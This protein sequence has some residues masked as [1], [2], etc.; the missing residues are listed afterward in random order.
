MII[1]F[2][3]VEITDTILAVTDSFYVGWKQSTN[4]LL[5]I[6]LD[7]NTDSKNMRFFNVS[8][9][10]QKSAIDGSMMI[11]PIVSSKNVLGTSVTQALNKNLQPKFFPNPTN[12]ILNFS[13]LPYKSKIAVYNLMGQL[14]MDVINS[15][16]VDLGNL[17]AG[18]YFI[19]VMNSYNELLLIDKC[20]KL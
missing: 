8:G 19:K 12:S 1:Q 20:I 14:E 3:L 2:Q 6:G 18:V 5:N 7:R 16:Q 11:R 9:N 4:K 13:N 17:P 15:S 10:W